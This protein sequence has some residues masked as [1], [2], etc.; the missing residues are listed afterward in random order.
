MKKI[1]LALIIF[2]IC[3]LATH[4]QEEAREYNL[5]KSK[6]YVKNPLDL[7]DPFKRKIN[8]KKSLSQA[9]AQNHL[10][11]I[12]SN[13]N[14]SL[15]NKPLESLRVTGVVLGAER[16]AIVKVIGVT[17]ESGE[18][19]NNIYYLKEGMH[20]G[21]NGAEVKAILPGGVVLVEKIRNVYDQDEYLETVIPVSND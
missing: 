19:D 18:K 3:T 2:F 13:V 1:N 15:E 17:T 5:F 4:A 20:V 7:R 21:E 10:D 14:T 8:K 11:G 16:R 6:T 9:K 12:Y